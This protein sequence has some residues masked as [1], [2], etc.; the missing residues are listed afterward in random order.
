MLVIKGYGGD[1]DGD[2]MNATILIDNK[3]AELASAFD[4]HY[5]IVDLDYFKINKILYIPSTTVATIA[6]YLHTKEDEIID[7]RDDLALKE[8]MRINQ[9]LSS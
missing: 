9:E 6:N 7:V 2:E 1:F 8:L 3:L 4:Y 5:N